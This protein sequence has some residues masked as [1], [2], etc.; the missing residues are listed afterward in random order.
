M[1]RIGTILALLAG[2]VWLM[3]CTHAELHHHTEETP[4]FSAP[5]CEHCHSCEEKTCVKPEAAVPLALDAPVCIPVRSAP[6]FAVFDHSVPVFT[7]AP[8]PPER[9]QLLLTVQFL[10]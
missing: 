10:I 4:V 8:R 1:R 6:Q 2:L 3:P 9:L 5:E 7:P